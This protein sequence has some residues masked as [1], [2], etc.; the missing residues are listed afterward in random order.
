MRIQS[1]SADAG[2][3]GFTFPI[4]VECEIT[5]SARELGAMLHEILQTGHHPE[6]RDVVIKEVRGAQAAGRLDRW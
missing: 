5:M 1:A 2:S 4:K 3:A 6:L